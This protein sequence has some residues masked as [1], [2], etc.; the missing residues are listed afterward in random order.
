M[1]VGLLLGTGFL[2]GW[3]VV[4]CLDSA[5]WVKSVSTQSLAGLCRRCICQDTG[6]EAG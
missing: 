2:L 3:E 4:L 5:S 6:L 1:Q